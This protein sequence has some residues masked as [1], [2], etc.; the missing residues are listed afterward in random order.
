VE[1]WWRIGG[2]LVEDWWSALSP[3][4]HTTLHLAECA[5][6][7]RK[8]AFP[9]GGKARSRFASRAGEAFLEGD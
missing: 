4:P 9:F 6:P 7:A 3:I 5:K 2:G 8:R 1:G